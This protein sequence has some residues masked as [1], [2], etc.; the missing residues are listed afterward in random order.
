MMAKNVLTDTLSEPLNDA[1]AARI[2][3]H[4]GDGN[5]SIDR[6]AGGGEVL[7]SGTLQYF[8]G[9]GAPARILDS[10]NGQATFTL[11]GG[12]SLR[13]RFRMPWSACNGESD[14][15]IHL[16]PEVSTDLTAHSDGGNLK[17]NLDG[18]VVTRVSADTGGGNIEVILP[19]HA[20]QLSVTARTGGGNVTVEMGNDIT[21]SNNL[22]ATSGAGNVVAH[23][24]QGVAARIHA[25]TGMGRVIVDSRF[26]QADKFTYE[27][28]DFDHAPNKVE[29]TAS[30]G[31][32][33]VIVETN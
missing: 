33:N 13:P 29:I 23:I 18:M 12:N 30:S 28:P 16:N 4:A 1:T 27:S 5:L 22:T 31:A 2:S 9:Q 24:P 7:A 10:S 32:G 3:I 8:E 6:L 19:D 14:W 25:K 15:Q 20:S 21:G 17:L 26:G 11:K